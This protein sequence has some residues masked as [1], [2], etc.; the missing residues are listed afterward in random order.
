ME[1]VSIETGD[2][3]RSV[4]AKLM[5]VIYRAF[6]YILTVNYLIQSLNLNRP[7]VKIFENISSNIKSSI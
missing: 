4:G 2:A 7:K 3:S 1:L 6:H 5:Q